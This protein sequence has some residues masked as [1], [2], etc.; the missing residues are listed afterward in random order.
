MTIDSLWLGMACGLVRIARADIDAWIA[1]TGPGNRDDDATRPIR[2][3]VFDHADGVR[4]FVDASY[5]TAPV[6]KAAD[7]KLW[8]M[9][10]D[11]VSV[12][13]PRRLPFN[14]S[15]AAGSRRAGHRRPQDIRCRRQCGRPREPAGADARPAD[16]LHGA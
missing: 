10:P 6:A 7:G 1:A 15:S 13:D 2:T 5:Y 11:G 8:F 16:R 4:M 14:T 9:S 3:T 12:V